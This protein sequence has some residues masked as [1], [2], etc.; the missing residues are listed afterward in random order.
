MNTTILKFRAATRPDS[1]V[2]NPSNL[3]VLFALD[4]LQAQR[5]RLVAHWHRHPDGRLA[6]AWEPD[7]SFRRDR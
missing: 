6:C 4:R 3:V 7:L 1:V 5:P 2:R